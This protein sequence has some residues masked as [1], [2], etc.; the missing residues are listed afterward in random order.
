MMT[1]IAMVMVSGDFGF[2][3]I[4]NRVIRVKKGET[5]VTLPC[6][7]TD[8][9]GQMSLLKIFPVVS[10]IKRRHMLDHITH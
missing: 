8:P 9:Y 3:A 7:A 2:P 6:K 10:E 1:I 5:F 4:R